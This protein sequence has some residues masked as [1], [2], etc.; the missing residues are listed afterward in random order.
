MPAESR[1]RRRGNLTA[2]VLA[3]G[4]GR[5]LEGHG[6]GGSKAMVAIAGRPLIVWVVERLQAAGIEK[7]IIVAHAADGLLQ[8]LVRQR[9]PRARLAVQEQRLGIADAAV[10][11]LSAMDVPRPCL[12]CACDSLF[13]AA[14]IA[15]VVRAGQ[16]AP[17]AAVVGVQRMGVEATAA[18]SAVELR[19][20]EVTRI[21]EKPAPG[22]TAS[23]FVAVPLYW[24]TPAVA[25]YLLA[26]APVGG[27]K[28]ISTALNDFA[29]AGGCVIAVK[30]A[31]RIEITTAADVHRAA[32]RLR[33]RPAGAR[34]S[35]S[36]PC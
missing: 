25:P 24:L 15:A 2:V 16:A 12:A 1:T 8:E 33:Q 34:T 3:A 23:P 7:V 29:A 11:G 17:G 9:M 31:G 22:T 27:E 6:N 28:H 13:E 21:I 35:R 5:R 4:A 18:R 10:R 20:Y 19:G 14:D 32:R 30:V 26:A 36:T